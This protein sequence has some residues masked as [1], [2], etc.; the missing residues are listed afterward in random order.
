MPLKQSE[1]NAVLRLFDVLASLSIH[2]FPIDKV[3]FA[4]A[5]PCRAPLIFELSHDCG[6]IGVLCVV[7]IVQ[8]T[9]LV[10]ARFAL[11]GIFHSHCMI[12]RLSYAADSGV[13]ESLFEQLSDKT[14]RIACVD[15]LTVDKAFE[16]IF[17]V[18][19]LLK[20]V[21]FFAA[22][23]VFFV[24]KVPE[25]QHLFYHIGIHAEPVALCLI[26][27]GNDKHLVAQTVVCDDGTRHDMVDLTIA[28]F[29]E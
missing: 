27:R 26:C 12:E 11:F 1:H 13:G 23:K 2:I 18:T 5:S 28:Q 15:Q 16:I 19:R 14:D 9:D 24:Q 21:E 29:I 20:C 10:K 8:R 17:L 4:N 3:H 22:D 25:R 7:H 6:Q